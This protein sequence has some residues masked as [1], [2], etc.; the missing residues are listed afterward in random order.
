[1]RMTSEAIKTYYRLAKPGIIY[2]NILVA[3]AGFIYASHGPILWL[4]GFAMLAGLACVI[5]SACVFNNYI[6]RDL[7]TKMERTKERALAKRQI[8]V[9]NALVFGTALLVVGAAILYF[10]TNLLALTISLTGFFIYVFLYSPLKPRTPYAL[11]VGAVAGATPPVVGYVTATNAL[12][13]TAGLLFLF[14]FFWQLPHFLA[15]AVYRNEEY[16]TAGV[17]LFMK[18]PYTQPQ[19]KAGRLVFY[20]SLVVLLAWCLAL[21]LQR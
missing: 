7:D 6:D 20:L 11:F 15:I 10:C 9:R 21:M 8:P 5:G 13:I 14:L 1:M 4:N 18:G 3:G 19:K 16:I 2:G 12:D 17:P